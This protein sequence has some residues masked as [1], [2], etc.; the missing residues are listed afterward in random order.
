MR[1]RDFFGPE[2][3]SVP[4]FTEIFDWGGEGGLFLPGS[5]GLGTRKMMEYLLGTFK[6]MASFC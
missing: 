5:Q 6:E 4:P 2:V 3:P 1:R